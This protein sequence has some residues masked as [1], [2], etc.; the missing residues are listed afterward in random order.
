MGDNE[1]PGSLKANLLF[2]IIII[3][4]IIII[5]IITIIVISLV[6][7]S[8]YSDSNPDSGKNFSFSFADLVPLF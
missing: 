1:Y 6:H 4:I 5:I 2:I 3:N 8:E 7:K